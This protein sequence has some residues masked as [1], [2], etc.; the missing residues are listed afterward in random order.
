MRRN[1]RSGYVAG[2]YLFPGGAV[3]DADGLPDAVALCQGRT[4]AEASTT[5]GV[6]SGGLAWWVAGIRECFEEAGILLAWPAWASL[7]RSSE[8]TLSRVGP[9]PDVLGRLRARRGEIERA[10]ERFLDACKIEGLRLAAGA[11]HA[12]SH[13]VTPMGAPRRYDTWFFIGVSPAG[14]EPVPDGREV[15]DALWTVPSEALALHRAGTLDLMLPTVENLKLLEHFVEVQALVSWISHRGAIKTICPRVRNGPAGPE[16][17]LPGE[18]GYDQVSETEPLPRGLPL[19]G[20][21][22]SLRPA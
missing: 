11:L 16:I 1:S 9:S 10:P 14:Q 3:D 20:R 13:W 19:P 17:V 5:L 22:G 2:V 6:A 12:M 7:S 18:L 15:V 4:D 21:P 8:A